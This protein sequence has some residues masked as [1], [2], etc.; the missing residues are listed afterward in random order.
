MELFIDM[1]RT[2]CFH[3]NEYALGSVTDACIVT[4][5]V[6]FGMGI[7]CYSV[8][9]GMERNIFVGSSILHMYSKY[10]D[11]KAAKRLFESSNEPNLGCWNAMVEG[12]V[13]CRYG[14]E[15]VNTVCFMHPKGVMDEF[16]L[17]LAIHGLIVRKGFESTVTLMNSLINMYF[18]VGANEHAWTLFHRMEHKDIASWNTILSVSVTYQ[19][20]EHNPKD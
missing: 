3:A 5:D 6:E 20:G 15:A 1:A 7:R 10:G 11:I 16:T 18:N 4:E 9:I 8:R 14:L 17:I 12:C 2:E 19:T 13:Q